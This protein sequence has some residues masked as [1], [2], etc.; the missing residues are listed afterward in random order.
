MEISGRSE[1]DLEKGHCADPDTALTGCL[2]RLDLQVLA[3]ILP[4]ERAARPDLPIQG[5]SSSSPSFSRQRDRPPSL[6]TDAVF[7]NSPAR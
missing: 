1:L 3:L 7:A 2:L 6:F 4:S 5:G